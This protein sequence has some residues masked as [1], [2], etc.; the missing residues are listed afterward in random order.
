MVK[1]RPWGHDVQVENEEHD[2]QLEESHVRQ[3]TEVLAVDGA[4]S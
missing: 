4:E 1:N 2:R 3:T